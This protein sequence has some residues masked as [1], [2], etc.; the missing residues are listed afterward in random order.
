MPITSCFFDLDRSRSPTVGSWSQIQAV[1][2][3]DLATV[4]GDE[5]DPFQP[6]AFAFAVPAGLQGQNHSRLQDRR[7]GGNDTWFFVKACTD[8]VTGVMRVVQPFPDQGVE[9][10]GYHPGL[11]GGDGLL[12]AVLDPAVN[13]PGGGGG[14]S[15]R[16]RGARVRPI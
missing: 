9:V 8:P 7:P 14:H 5:H 15:Y 3:Q 13:G 11:D 4:A 6:D 12:Q 16:D 10:A 2:R 1:T